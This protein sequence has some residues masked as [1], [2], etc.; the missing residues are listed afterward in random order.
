[1]VTSSRRSASHAFDLS[2]GRLALDFVNTVSQRGSA[3]PIDHLHAY[4]DLLAWAVQAGAAAPR[5]ARPLAARASAHPAEA[6]RVL[7]RAI[8]VREALFRLF[9]AV[10]GSRA[11]RPDD[12]AAVNADLP[13]AFARSRIAAS[14]GQFAL[15]VA[16]TA[17]DLASPLAPVIRSAVDLLTSSDVDRVR[18]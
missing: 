7:A 2:G 17:D 18:K 1:M 4:G 14:G 9:A 8:A 6:R 10:A 3:E 12:L 15:S 5:V 16:A 11:P 13:A